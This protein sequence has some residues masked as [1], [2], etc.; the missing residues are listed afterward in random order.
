LCFVA[1]LLCLGCRNLQPDDSVAPSRQPEELIKTMKASVDG[2][3][4]TYLL[5][6]PAGV[7]PESGWPL[8]LF[9]HGY[10]ECGSDIQKV[11]KHGPPKLISQFETLQQ[12]VIVSP[13]CPS[14]SWWRVGALRALTEEVITDM[15]DVDRD[16]LYVTGLSMGGYG[17]W[18]LASNY[19]DYFAA[20]IPICGG[21]DPFRLPANRPPVKTGIVNEYI[22][23]GLKS[24]AELPVWAF[25][26]TDD[27]SVP[28]KETQMLVDLLREGGNQKVTFTAYEGVG[29]VGAWERAYDDPAVWGWLFAR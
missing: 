5:Q 19:P 26:G 25:H 29:H 8:L 12:C 28:I 9:L 20:A 14:D 23:S 16:R 17:S 1:A 4:L 3:Q 7:Q 2:H 21:G 27:S 15:G 13:Q 6:T 10:G 22:P 18:C 24:A 11:R